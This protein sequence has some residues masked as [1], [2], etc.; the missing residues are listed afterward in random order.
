MHK[1]MD[2]RIELHKW[3]LASQI[4][5]ILLTLL[6]INI[7]MGEVIFKYLIWRV[8]GSMDLLPTYYI[9]YLCTSLIN[10]A[11]SCQHC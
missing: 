10:P 6:V 3:G 9:D 4:R 8:K 7:S 1:I 5:P 11:D 2:I